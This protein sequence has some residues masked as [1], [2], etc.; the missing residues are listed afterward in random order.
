MAIWQI[1]IS[2]NFLLRP[3]CVGTGLAVVL[4]SGLLPAQSSQPSS[5][6]GSLQALSI[7]IAALNVELTA[8]AASA[9]ASPSQVSQLLR[10]RTKSL[11]DMIELSPSQAISLSFQ[12]DTLSRLRAIAPEAQIESRG[13]WEGVLE[14]VVS[15]DFEHQRSRTHWYLRTADR[16]LELFGSHFSALHPGVTAKVSGVAMAGRVAAESLSVESPRATQPQQCS[17]IGVQNTAVF[18]VTMPSFPAFEPGVTAASVRQ[19][20]FGSSADTHSTDS[21]NGIWREMSYG[22]TSVTGQVFGPFALGH[23][24]SCGQPDVVLDDVIA[25]FDGSTDFAQF[26]RFV[27]LM[28]G[29][30]CQSV[31]GMASLGCAQVTSPSKGTLAAS[32]AW[33]PTGLNT[34][35]HIGNYVESLGHC[36]GLG[37]STADDYINVPLGPLGI[38]GSIAEFGD[39][40]SVMG[41]ATGVSPAGGQYTGEHKSLILHWLNSGEY[42]EVRT[43]GT[44]TLA[45]Y[46]SSSGL[47]ALRVLRDA[48]TSAWLWLEYRQPIGDVDN[49]FNPSQV[50]D[51]NVYNGVLVHYEDP[52]LS[53]VNTYLIDFNRASDA[54]NF[55]HA[56]LNATKSWSDPYSPLTLTVN[57][58]LWSGLSVTVNYDQL[59]AA[60]QF[61][62]TTFS[63]SGGPATIN[64]TAGTGCSWSASASADWITI[65][66]QSSGQGSNTLGFN[67]APNT[68]LQQRRSFITIARQSIPIVQEGTAGATV[69]GVTPKVGTGSSAQFSFQ[70]TDSLGY[71]DIAIVDL[72]FDDWFRG[73]G[74]QV[75]T[76]QGILSFNNT[77]VSLN[78]QASPVTNGRCT[79]YPNAS[80]IARL[81]NTVTVTVQISFDSLFAGTHLLSADMYTSGGPSPV[82]PLGTWTVPAPPPSALSISKTHFGTFFQGQSSALYT[83]MVSN[84][85]TAGSTSGVVTVTESLPDG[86]ALVS[87][88]GTGWTCPGTAANN[89]T[90]SDELVAGSSY[91]PLIVIVNVSANAPPQVTNQVSLS[92]G[93]SSGVSATDVTTVTPHPAALRFVP[94]TP[95]RL[96]DTRATSNGPFSGPSLI[97]KTTRDFVIPD[98]SCGIPSTAAAYSLN[99]TVVPPASVGFVTVWPSGEPMPLSSTMNSPDARIKANAAIVA[100]G[101][102]G[103]VSFYANAA[104]DLVLDI[105]GYFVPAA[106]APTALAFYPLTPCRIADTRSAGLALLGTPSLIAKQNRT[107]PVLSSSCNVPPSAQAYSLNL[108]AVP[109][110]S[111]G[112]VTAWPTGQ[113][114]PLASVL[115]D[116]TGTD[117]ANAAI[118]PAGN[119]GAVDV[120]ANAAT[121]LIIDINGYF[122]APGA[123]G[124]SLYN[125]TPCRVLDTRVPSGSQPFKGELDV[126][127][128][129][130]ACGVPASAQAY[131]F[132]AT[133]VPP[134][135]MGFL[136]LW[137]QGATR[138]IVSTLNALDGQIT[139]NRAIVPTT[140]GSVASY[141]NAFTQLILDVFGYFAP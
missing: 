57:S 46:E 73:C 36:L 29:W 43:S 74:M 28:P 11:T 65:T 40:Y 98:S 71:T 77:Q 45:P 130:T 87:M 48:G 7:R 30:S 83:V 118:I 124:L 37:D 1:D 58:A 25:A 89:C 60:P 115:N 113:T 112:F 105:D 72:L 117:V 24:Y 127:V 86:L 139:S 97:A 53:D 103:A 6:D 107:F 135:G 66:G 20:F 96:V 92:G 129:P 79:V 49:I 84:A 132:N 5:Q 4:L 39:L 21:L 19:L 55:Y 69:S 33:I 47:R 2:M 119:G 23:D 67:V 111:L 88:S 35:Q 22:L 95:C 3:A 81:G 16:K 8:S 82:V 91:A 44:F 78:T 134:A 100:A 138:P 116:L 90:R 17:T 137:P 102:G 75:A 63:S 122:A 106:T 131:V 141:A 68:G 41:S 123:G 128:S 120:Y 12:A 64:V 101:A 61:S 121:D 15:D 80:Y 108:T 54:N 110:G 18:M 27:V 133:V 136:T 59:C 104:T 31:G 9:S 76:N 126:N 114:R 140:N 38:P 52:G 34:L 42:E 85:L 125:L 109:P 50:V 14:T 70:F 94:I 10:E 56:A 93:G 26:T 62:A 13:D 32:K 51:T 99:V